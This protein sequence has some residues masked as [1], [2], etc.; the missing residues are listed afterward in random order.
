[1]SL[2]LFVKFSVQL[3]AIEYLWKMDLGCSLYPLSSSSPNQ[4]FSC[5]S[6]NA[7]VIMLCLSVFIQ[8]KV[9]LTSTTI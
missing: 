5:L 8:I 3:Q 9:Y 6:E 2:Y 7:I 4:E 1:M